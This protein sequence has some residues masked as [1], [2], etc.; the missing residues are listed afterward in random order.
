MIKRRSMITVL[1]MFIFCSILFVRPVRSDCGVSF[2]A[3][4]SVP[5]TYFG[6]RI[7]SE[8]R[9]GYQMDDWVERGASSVTESPIFSD[10]VRLAA[11]ATLYGDDYEYG[12]ASAIYYF[13]IPRNA[14][15]IKVKIYYDGE[16]DRDDLNNDI[17]GRVWIKRTIIGD[18]FEEYYPKEGRYE[19]ADTALYGD[20]FVLPARK[21]FEIIRLSAREHSEDG[22]MELHVVAEGRQRVDV[23]YIEVETYSSEPN[24]RVITRYY[25]DYS[26]RPWYDYTY[27]YFYSGPIFYFSDYYYVRYTYPNYRRYY[28]EVRRYYNDYLRIYYISRPYYHIRWIDVVHVKP[29]VPRNWNKDRLSSWTREHDELRK[30]YRVIS[31][32]NHRSVDVEVSRE[33]IRTVL[34]NTNRRSPSAIHARSDE[35]IQ[36]RGSSVTEMKMRRDVIEQ[37]RQVTTP[38]VR[39]R[40]QDSVRSRPT[41]RTQDN[42]E[43]RDN[44]KIRR[45]SVESSIRAQRSAVEMKRS[46]V[47]QNKKENT[48][49]R[50]PTRVES[51]NNEKRRREVI[52]EETKKEEQRKVERAPKREES[53]QK[54]ETNKNDDNDDDD[55][56][57]KNSESSTS[58]KRIRRN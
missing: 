44:I 19:D 56:D 18:D 5:Y 34:S 7:T 25:K 53:Q 2:G 57:K 45:E 37:P 47:E 42:T 6:D 8:Y 40:T 24:I 13:D 14:R 30:S 4:Y 58:R 39:T 16:P 12:I 1:I 21:R 22:I 11:W 52:K 29:G 20:T 3:S 10:G 17:V 46:S 48:E 23:K 33:R 50:A 27:W 38:E 49:R 32:K 36:T 35:S 41:E 26:W 51:N 31:M 43:T 54:V 15:S 9:R 55:E 28:V